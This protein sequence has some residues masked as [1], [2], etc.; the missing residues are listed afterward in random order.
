VN[1]PYQF[2]KIHAHGQWDVSLE[3]NVPLDRP[4]LSDND[5]RTVLVSNSEQFMHAMAVRAICI[6]EEAALTVDQA[7]D[8]N[9]YQATHVLVYAKREPIGAARIRWFREFAKIERTAF[10]PAYRNPR[11]LVRSAHFIF[12]H[13]ARKGYDRLFTH[14]EPKF[15][16]VWEKLLGFERVEAR[17]PVIIGGH[18]P[19]IELV[20]ALAPPPDAITAETEPKIL[21]RVEG[22]WDVP[23]AFE[24]DHER[25]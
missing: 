19:Y 16:R 18:E 14:A 8:G 17:P 2:L 22:Q 4:L 11:V 9:D 1:L 10:R 3:A 21:F 13:V 15:A 5:I 24:A 6:L 25:T 12:D 20:K 23:G 7:I